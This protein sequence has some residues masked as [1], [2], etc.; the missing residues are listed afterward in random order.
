MVIPDLHQT[1]SG[2]PA[3]GDAS[4]FYNTPSQMAKLARDVG[5][6]VLMGHSQSSSFPTRAA[7]QPESGCYPW[8]SAK[9][10]KV[11]GIIQIETGCFGN[12]TADQI[13]T[14]KRIP[15]L[16]VAGDFYT[17]PQPPAVCVTMMDQI[18]GAGGDMR[19]AH[20]P[21]LTKN[22]L[23]PGSPGPMP[24][25]EHMMMIGTKNIDVAKMLIGWIDHHVKRKSNRHDDDDDDNRGHR[26]H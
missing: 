5:G 20:L 18:N 26:R 21:A 12:L 1:L 11:K 19:F 4:G 25:I 24:G 23:Y 13:N 14:L 16:I 17:V 22:S 10:C 3:P 6:A 7:L 2:H 15:I 9:A 8:T